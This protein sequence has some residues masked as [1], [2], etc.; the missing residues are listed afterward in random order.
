MKHL[1]SRVFLILVPVTLI[2]ALDEWIKYHALTKLPGEGSL[3]DPGLIDFAIHK[4]LGIAFNIP[5][6]MPI[7][8]LVSL[9]IG[10]FLF[11]VLKNNLKNHPDISAAAAMIMIGA[12]GNLYDRITYAFTVDYIILFGRLAINLSDLVIVSGVIWL[13]M[14]SRRSKKHYR[15]HPNEA[16]R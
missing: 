7:I 13:L 11:Q 14:A 5:F 8:I 15:I 4:N 12:L 6:K 16:R 10:F 2:V 3:V 1:G 9:I